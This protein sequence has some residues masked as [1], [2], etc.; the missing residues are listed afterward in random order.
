MAIQGFIVETMDNIVGKWNSV[1][2]KEGRV[3]YSFLMERT[4]SLAHSFSEYRDS[5]E[6]KRDS[7]VG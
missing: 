2:R 3:T 1:R 4:V 5:Q 6:A 7:A